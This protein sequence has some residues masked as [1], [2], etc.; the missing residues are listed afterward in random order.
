MP[1]ADIGILPECRHLHMRQFTLE[2]PD[3]TLAARAITTDGLWP[4]NAT[5]KGRRSTTQHA[6]LQGNL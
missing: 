6:V 5:I 2:K 4:Y 1:K 3:E